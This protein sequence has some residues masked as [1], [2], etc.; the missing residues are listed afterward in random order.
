MYPQPQSQPQPQASATAAQ[1]TPIPSVAISAQAA[2]Q[3]SDTARVEIKESTY[4]AIARRVVECA[5]EQEVSHLDSEEFGNGDRMI[6]IDGTIYANQACEVE[7][8]VGYSGVRIIS[9]GYE[10]ACTAFDLEGDSYVATDFDQ[11]RLDKYL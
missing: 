8:E 4:Q 11:S 3:M 6:F 5:Y 1:P 9:L 10:L 7:Q 2:D